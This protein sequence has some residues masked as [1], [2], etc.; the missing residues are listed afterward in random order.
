MDEDEAGL[1]TSRLLVHFNILC[2]FTDTQN[3]ACN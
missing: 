2:N 1:S 3:K